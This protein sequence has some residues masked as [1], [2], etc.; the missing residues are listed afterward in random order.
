MR[1]RTTLTCL[2]SLSFYCPTADA[3]IFDKDDRRLVDTSPGS[4]YAPIGLV[5]GAPRYGT[6][7]LIDRC[8]VLTAQHLFDSGKSPVGKR[9]TFVGAVGSKHP[10][11]SGGTVV[12]AGGLERHRLPA[13]QLEARGSDWL[14]IKLDTC[15]GETLNWALLSAKTPDPAELTRMRS[16]GF[17]NDR[18]RRTGLTIDPACAIRSVRPLVWLNDCAAMPGDSGGPIFR[19]VNSGGQQHLEVV[20]IQSAAIRSRRAIPLQPGWENQATPAW[21]IVPYIM[22]VHIAEKAKAFVVNPNE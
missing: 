7:T 20:A 8:H 16:A 19:I 13:E 18:Q 21:Q 22:N 10:V 11:K 2:F 9:L 5:S 17:P 1:F 6:G 12:A 3:A 14:L 15:L 4:V